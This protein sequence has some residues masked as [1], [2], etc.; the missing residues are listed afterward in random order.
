MKLI[1]LT[2]KAGAGKYVKVDKCGYIIAMRI[3]KNWNIQNG[4]ACTKRNNKTVY[5][6]RLLMSFPDQPVDHIDGDR[7]N[8]RLT[9]LRATSYSTQNRNRPP[10]RKGCLGVK[11]VDL[12]WRARIRVDGKE[13]SL[14]L[15]ACKDDARRAYRDAVIKMDPLLADRFVDEWSDL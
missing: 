11:Q 9:N 6:H 10:P 13:K 2:G 1:A 3:T 12:K 8:C 14:G 15:F 4:Y 5:L 7:L